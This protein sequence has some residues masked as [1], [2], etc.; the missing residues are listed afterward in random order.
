M[1][2]NRE[3]MSAY[4]FDVPD[5]RYEVRLRFAEP[6]KT[7]P[8]ERVFTVR[9]GDTVLVEHLDLVAAAGS[10]T[11]HD[12]VGTA[13]VVAGR[14]LVVPFDGDIGLPVVSAVEVRKL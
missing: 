7:S 12:V 9:L 8:G 2:P 4:R 11:A 5:G 13:E 1:F 10:N 6:V 3:G 14:G